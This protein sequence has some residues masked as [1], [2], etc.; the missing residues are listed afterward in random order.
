MTVVMGGMVLPFAL[1]L[2]SPFTPSATHALSIPHHDSGIHME[3]CTQFCRVDF[4]F[5]MLISVHLCFRGWKQ[6][7]DAPF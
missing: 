1:N 6:C 7:L 2:R 5:P 4:G 3:S